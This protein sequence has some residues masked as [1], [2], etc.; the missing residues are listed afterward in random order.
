MK[1]IRH[2]LHSKA[3]AEREDYSSDHGQHDRFKTLCPQPDMNTRTWQIMAYYS[4]IIHQASLRTSL[5]SLFFTVMPYFAPSLSFE[6][7]YPW[8][9]RSCP[10]S[11]GRENLTWKRFS[12]RGSRSLPQ[13]LSTAALCVNAIVHSPCSMMPGSPTFTAKSLLI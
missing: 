12:L 10:G 1:A 13:R 9:F 5:P 8:N 4:S 6:I 11:T 2:S 7:A 3:E